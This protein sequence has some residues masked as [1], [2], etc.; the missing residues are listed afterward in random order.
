MSGPTD[1]PRSKRGI[2]VVD[3]RSEDLLVVDA[4]LASPRYDL[5][6]VRSGPEALRHLLERDFFPELEHPVVGKRRV[7]GT[8]W[9]FDSA[10]VGIRT[11]APLIGQ[12]NDAVLGGI[13]G[14]SEAEI[15]R[16]V[17]DGVVH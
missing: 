6:K 14:L 7:V 4:V 11:P 17:A 8:P 5:V 10:D 1:E 2:L 12:H 16:L 9:R 3:D 15:A 13:L